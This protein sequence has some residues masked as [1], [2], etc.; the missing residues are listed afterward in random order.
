M[1]KEDSYYNN[2]LI[3]IKYIYK[4]NAYVNVYR[5]NKH[6]YIYIY[7]LIY[8]QLFHQVTISFVNL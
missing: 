5:I 3:Y 2:N 1:F 8:D 4:R 6:F 7:I